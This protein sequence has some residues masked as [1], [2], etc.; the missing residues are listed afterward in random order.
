MTLPFVRLPLTCGRYGFR[1]IRFGDGDEA[2]IVGS[3]EHDGNTLEAYLGGDAD[4]DG[5]AVRIVQFAVRARA[6]ERCDGSFAI[7]WSA[8][9]TGLW[10]SVLHGV[11]C[12]GAVSECDRVEEDL[13]RFVSNRRAWQSTARVVSYLI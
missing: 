6:A 11:T 3:F 5:L 12:S 10:R 1:T 4:L 8:F 9:G 2:P 13:L 7:D